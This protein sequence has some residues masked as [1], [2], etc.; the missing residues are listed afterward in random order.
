M[1]AFVLVGLFS[2]GEHFTRAAQAPQQSAVAPL[3]GIHQISVY[4]CAL[5]GF[6]EFCVSQFRT[7]ISWTTSLEVGRFSRLDCCWSLRSFAG[8]FQRRVWRDGWRVIPS[9]QLFLLDASTYTFYI[10][11]F[12]QYSVLY[13]Y[14]ANGAEGYH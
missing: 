9:T 11:R 7:K 5:Q 2:L 4:H 13:F 14:A 1:I 10:D 12:A 3:F 6:P 8:G